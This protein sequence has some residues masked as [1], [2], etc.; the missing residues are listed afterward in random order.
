MKHGVPTVCVPNGVGECVKPFLDRN[1]ADDSGG[2][3]GPLAGK[4]DVDGGRMDGFIRVTAQ[5]LIRRCRR[6]RHSSACVH[7]RHPNVM[8]YHDGGQIPNYWAYARDFVL[9][10]HMF[11]PNWGWS[12]PAHLWLVSGWSAE[13]TRPVQG[14]HL[15]DESRL[16]ARAER[17]APPLSATGRS[18]AGPTSPISS[19]STGSPGRRTCRKASRPTASPAR[20]AAT[21]SC[22]APEH[23]RHVGS[24]RRLHRR[25][26][27]PPERRLAG[28]APALLRR[29]GEGHAAER[30]VGHARLG[31]QRPSRR[32][33]R[34]GAGVGDDSS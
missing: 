7:L 10:D 13:C 11:E 23:A 32:A 19:T 33:D 24:A 22:K 1:G 6:N 21:R 8:S 18:T 4:E 30:L 9:Q 20:S 25:P 3:H 29:G 5:K 12:L 28:A 27:G 15:H 2:A 34:R 16:Q 17:A 31:R 26:P 14:E